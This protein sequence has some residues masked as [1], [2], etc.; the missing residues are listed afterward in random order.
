VAT[1]SGD[2][3]GSDRVQESVDRIRELNER[4][5]ENARKAGITY[6]DAYESMLNTIVG[7]QEGIA[8]AAPV[9]WLQRMLEAQANFTR[10][11]G[12]IYAK[13]ARDMLTRK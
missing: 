1:K 10:Q 3:K 9:D 8:N 4:V 2:E 12:N 13:S 7:Y 5:L 6:L 11:I